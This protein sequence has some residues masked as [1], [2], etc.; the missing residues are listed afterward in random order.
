[1][2]IAVIPSGDIN[3][4][5]NADALILGLKGFCINTYAYSFEEIVDILNIST[6]EIFIAINKN[7]H[8]NEIPLLEEYLQKFSKMKIAGI[9]YADV[10]LIEINK[11]HNL[12]LNLIWSQEHLTCN[13]HTINYWLNEGAKG[14][15]IS[16]DITKREILE[17][18]SNV[19]GTKFVQVFGYIP[20]YVSRRHAVDNYLKAFAIKDKDKYFNYISKEEKDYPIVDDENGTYV[21]S[22]NILCSLNEIEEYNN[23]DYGIIS[24][25]NINHDEEKIIDI[26]KTVTNKNKEEYMDFIKDKYSNIDTI[27]LYTET[28]YKVK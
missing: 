2:K 6:Q 5:K 11:E 25:F 3:K 22:N 8:N 12:N 17:I 21:Y 20:I 4:Y 28:I 7:I 18:A 27:F 1:M 16:N 26:F 14:V 23:I 9:F 13:Y 19:N 24:F 10:A 15:F